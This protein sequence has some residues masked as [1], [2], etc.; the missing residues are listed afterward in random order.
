MSAVADN[1]RAVMDSIEAA[2]KRSGRDAGNVRLVVVSKTVAADVVNEAVAAGAKILGENRVQEALPKMEAVGAGVAWHLIGTL[3]KNKAKHAVGAFELIHSL[4]GIEL[5]RELARQ[6]VKRGIVQ[7]AL[8]EVNVAG[9]S[10]KHGVGPDAAMSLAREAAALSGLRITGLMCIP[11]FTENPEDSRPYFR[12]LKGLLKE[13]NDAGFPMS[14][15][16]MG[17]TQDYEVAVEEGATLVRVGTAIF[18]HRG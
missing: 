1:L 5:A 7:D 12:R 3:Q 13:L 2:A 10:T 9:E 4:D 15:L 6:A 11:P 8:I 18:G 14:E 17:M 16:S